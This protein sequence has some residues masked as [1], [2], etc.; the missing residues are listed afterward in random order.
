MDS[1]NEKIR[2]FLR[3]AGYDVNDAEPT[4][5]QLVRLMEEEYDFLVMGLLEQEWMQE[6]ID[7]DLESEEFT[8]FRDL[9][10]DQLSAY[11]DDADF[12]AF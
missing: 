9:I 11:R 7:R 1:M 5:L 4:G 12:D 8:D 6:Q 3:G 2:D 10:E